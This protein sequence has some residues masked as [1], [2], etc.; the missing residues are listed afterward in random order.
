MKNFILLLFVLI[1]TNIFSQV[2]KELSISNSSNFGRISTLYNTANNTILVTENMFVFETN[3]QWEF[4]K[5][6][7]INFGIIQGKKTR[8]NIFENFFF[9]TQIFYAGFGYNFNY[10][11]IELSTNINGTYS[12]FNSYYSYSHLNN[13]M[14]NKFGARHYGIMLKIIPKYYIKD[15]FYIG[16]NIDFFTGYKIDYSTGVTAG[17]KI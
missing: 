11:K 9:N 7:S 3:V 1:S 10:N 15:N 4:F 16:L 5:K 13:Y 6:V 14:T 2:P 8:N 17:F 12:N